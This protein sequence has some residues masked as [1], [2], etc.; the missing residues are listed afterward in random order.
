MSKV[1]R[2]VI[3]GQ[4]DAEGKITSWSEVKRRSN[5]VVYNCIESRAKEILKLQNDGIIEQIKGL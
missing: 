4:R 1:K 2:K 3:Y 5:D